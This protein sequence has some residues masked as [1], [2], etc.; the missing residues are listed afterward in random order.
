MNDPFPK[1]RDLNRSW[2][3]K[4]ITEDLKTLE[5]FRVRPLVVQFHLLS[6]RRILNVTDDHLQDALYRTAKKILEDELHML[7]SLEVER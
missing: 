7:E 5:S 3:I 6:E 2:R 1:L 4:V